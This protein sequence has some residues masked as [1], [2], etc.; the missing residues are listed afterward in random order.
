MQRK[1]RPH[2]LTGDPGRWLR[3]SAL[4][5]CL[6]QYGRRLV[7]CSSYAHDEGID[8]RLQPEL[9]QFLSGNGIDDVDRTGPLAQCDPVAVRRKAGNP[10]S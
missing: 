5:D 1:A 3:W 4:T 6:R 10:E 9:E 2:N 8:R 7:I